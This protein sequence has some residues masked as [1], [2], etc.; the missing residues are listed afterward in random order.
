MDNK[1]DN[2]EEFES[3]LKSQ[4]IPNV[5]YDESLQRILKERKKVVKPIYFRTSFIVVFLSVF[6]TV[7]VAA[8]QFTG[9]S[10]FNSNGEK[11]YEVLPSD[12]LTAKFDKSMLK[13]Q[14]IKEKIR[15]EIPEG[16]FVYFLP[17]DEYEELGFTTL[18]FL[19]NGATIHNLSEVPSEMNYIHLY[20]SLLNKYNFSEGTIYYEIPEVDSESIAAE[21]Y[22]EAK[23]NDMEYII[24]EGGKLTSNISSVELKYKMDESDFGGVT[25]HL[26]Q[27]NGGLMI[28]AANPEEFTEFTKITENGTEFLYH[29]KW[30]RLL[31]VV[32]DNNQ[33]ILVELSINLI[34]ENFDVNKELLPIALSLLN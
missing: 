3:R 33:K 18:L 1:I 7:S 23:K 21:L 24:Q 12:E 25:I 20:E 26:S 16:E 29:N 8:M 19:Y 17:V 11:I 6:I 22:K 13:Y 34:E 2:Y 15:K 9:F 27:T 28:T 31:F 5:H 32:E 4:N 10:L 30:Q 14:S